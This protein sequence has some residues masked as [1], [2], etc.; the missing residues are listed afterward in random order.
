MI[1]MISSCQSDGLSSNNVHAYF[2]NGYP[3]SNFESNLYSPSICYSMHLQMFSIDPFF[4]LPSSTN[5]PN[6]IQTPGSLY[7]PN[8]KPTT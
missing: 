1:P 7:Y 4:I 5:V 8:F 6:L 2:E 3:F